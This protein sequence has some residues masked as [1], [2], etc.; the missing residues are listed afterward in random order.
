MKTSPSVFILFFSLV[1]FF[2]L[3]ECKY[4]TKDGTHGQQ[5]ALKTES[6]PID[7]L[8]DS[9]THYF[10]NGIPQTSPAISL[11][12]NQLIGALQ[13]SPGDTVLL[14]LV[15]DS[16][17]NHTLILFTK[18]NDTPRMT[19]ITKGPVCVPCPGQHC[20]PDSLALNYFQHQP[21]N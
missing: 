2:F 21:V 6:E 12:K 14:S 4:E 20:C 10:D 8:Q 1:A 15:V 16:A 3:Q 19:I 13:E 9:L 5:N 7:N 11:N 18:P 17:L